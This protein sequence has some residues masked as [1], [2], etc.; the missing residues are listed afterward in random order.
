[1]RL[2]AQLWGGRISGNSAMS[3]IGRRGPQ[4]DLMSL[5]RHLQGSYRKYAKICRDY[6]Q[7]SGVLVWDSTW[8]S[9]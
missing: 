8:M 5:P 4:F 2:R 9:F 3:G 1:M 6:M 7:F